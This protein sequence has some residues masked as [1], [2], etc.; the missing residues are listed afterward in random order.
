[1]LLTASLRM[2]TASHGDGGLAQLSRSSITDLI[3]LSIDRTAGVLADERVSL[4][5]DANAHHPRH[6]RIPYLW[7]LI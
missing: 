1:M 4:Q 7:S 2:W 6:Q 5:R 3:K